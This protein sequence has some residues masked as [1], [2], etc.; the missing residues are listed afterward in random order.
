MRKLLM[1]L[2]CLGLL[3]SISA[4]GGGDADPKAVLNDYFD[5]MNDF[6]TGMEKA[7]SADDVVAAINKFSDGMEDLVPRMKSVQENYPELKNMGSQGKLPEEFK[8]FEEKFKELMPKMMGISAKLMKFAT[9]PKVME[10]QKKLTEAMSAL[11]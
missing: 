7:E 10:A 9:D 11:Q 3:I 2:V 5:V 1:I 8:E 4:C 6:L